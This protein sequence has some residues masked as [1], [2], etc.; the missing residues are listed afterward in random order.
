MC[1]WYNEDL[2]ENYDTPVIMMWMTTIRKLTMIVDVND[3]VVD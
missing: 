2:N 1:P 3:D